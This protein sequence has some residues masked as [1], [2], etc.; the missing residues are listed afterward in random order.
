MPAGPSRRTPRPMSNVGR[1]ERPAWGSSKGLSCQRV[2]SVATGSQARLRPER[3]QLDAPDLRLLQ[4]EG[5]AVHR[6]LGGG[7]VRVV[8][9][10]LGVAVVPQEPGQPES[11]RPGLALLRLLNEVQLQG[12]LGRVAPLR[13]G[14]A[15][16]VVPGVLPQKAGVGC[17][18]EQRV[19]ATATSSFRVTATPSGVRFRSRARQLLG[20]PRAL[21]GGPLQRADVI[22]DGDGGGGGARPLRHPEPPEAGDGFAVHRGAV[23]AVRQDP[24]HVLHRDAP[25]VAQ[26]LE[27]RVD[28]ACA[29]RGGSATKKRPWSPPSSSSS[30]RVQNPSSRI[31]WALPKHRYCQGGYL[32]APS[33]LLIRL[34]SLSTSSKAVSTSGF[35][36]AFIFARTPT[37]RRPWLPACHRGPASYRR[38]GTRS[39]SV[40]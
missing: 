40:R 9:L 38:G 23:Y 19:S 16:A 39:C 1:F 5:V 11:P 22:P 2:A 14:P 28:R 12:Y 34:T 20:G 29:V 31:S 35:S 13:R 37:W 17:G 36:L 33:C 6:A 3:G 25:V 26:F 18:P 24:A 10:W 7:R 4:Q 21:R 30:P 15:S 8:P 27:F 32:G